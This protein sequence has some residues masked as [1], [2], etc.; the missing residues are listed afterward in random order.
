MFPLVTLR[1]RLSG[2]EVDQGDLDDRMENLEVE[3]EAVGVVHED[4]E[5]PLPAAA[6]QVRVALVE[7]LG[8]HQV[9][10]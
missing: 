3:L 7:P 6:A 1:Q 8:H 5:R 10:S 9:F 2:R 4:P